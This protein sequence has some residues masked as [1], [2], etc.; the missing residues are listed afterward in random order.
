LLGAG[1]R[2]TFVS[3]MMAKNTP[4]RIVAVC[5]LRRKMER[6]KKTDSRQGRQAYLY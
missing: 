4:A 1:N 3:T 5:D 6:A 2:G